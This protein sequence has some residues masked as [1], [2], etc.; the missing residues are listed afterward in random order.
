MNSVKKKGGRGG[1]NR[2]N[3]RLERGT[4]RASN[5]VKDC[6]ELFGAGE[7]NAAFVR[8]GS[9][10]AHGGR[11]KCGGWRHWSARMVAETSA[12]GGGIGQH[13][14]AETSVVGGGW[15][16]WSARMVAETSVVG[17]G[18]GQH[19][20]WPKQVWFMFAPLAPNQVP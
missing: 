14:V 7:A 16:H 20:W 2:C 1:T 8:V 17:G 5:P 12:V 11:N 4:C 3:A 19:A 6:T 10:V 15:R 18:I 9:C 13:A